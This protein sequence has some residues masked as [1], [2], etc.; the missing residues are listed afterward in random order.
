MV[1][2]F[3]PAVRGL[4]AH[5][6]SE[7]G[8]S[9]GKVAA[10]LSVTQASVSQYLSNERDLYLRRLESLG[11]DRSMLERYVKLLSEEVMRSPVDAVFTLYTLWR[12]L[13]VSGKIRHSHVASLTVSSACEI[14]QRLFGTP[15]IDV[16]RNLVLADLDEAIRRIEASPNFMAIMPHVGVNMVLAAD[17]AKEETD[18]AGVPGRIVKVH[19]RA[20]A[21]TRPE[22]GVSRHMAQM[23]LTARRFNASFR[24]AVNIKYDGK[25]NRIVQA[26]RL[27][28]GITADKSKLKYTSGDIVVE[29]F[30]VALE[31]LGKS[32]PVIVDKGGPGLEPITYL[33]G[34][35]AQEVV[36][37]VLEI[38]TRYVR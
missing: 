35:T 4:L 38:A 10:A 7:K 2:S 8:V 26:M 5:E 28:V 18:I 20:K 15:K 6:L 19:D 17:K 30:H 27:Q 37:R 24:A 34:S 12:S 14:C 11:V 21:T 13:M 31:R 29:A 36:E 3:L 32:P 23:L 22:F 16:A 9:Q 1:D 33:F 25:V